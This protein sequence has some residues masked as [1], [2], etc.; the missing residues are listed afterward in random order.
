MVGLFAISQYIVTSLIPI[1]A[2]VKPKCKNTN[3]M[4]IR[5]VDILSAASRRLPETFVLPEL[6]ANSLYNWVVD[7]FFAGFLLP[8]LLLP[9]LSLLCTVTSVPWVVSLFLSQGSRFSNSSRILLLSLCS[10]LNGHISVPQSGQPP[11]PVF[12]SAGC[13]FL[14]SVSFT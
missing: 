4:L 13:W 6:A 3:V 2:L 11:H 12:G 7:F 10:E 1:L 9:P 14:V 8:L 5:Q